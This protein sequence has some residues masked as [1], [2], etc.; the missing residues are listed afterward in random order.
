MIRRSPEQRRDDVQRILDAARSVVERRA[1]LVSALVESTGLHR[2]GVE[3]ALLHCL[4]TSATERELDRLV[5]TAGDAPHVHVI[6]SANVFV[7]AL[8][9]IALARA[10]ARR[11]TVRP[12]SRDPVF[13]EHLVRAIA[14]PAIEIVPDALPRMDE[15]EI[16][17][18]GRDETIARVRASAPPGVVVRGHGAGMGVACISSGD[19]ARAADNLADDVVPFDQRGCLSPRVAFVVGELIRARDFAEKM[20]ASLAARQRTIPRGEL[21][22]VE[23]AEARRYADTLS[24]SGVLHEGEGHKVGVASHLVVPPSGRHVHVVPVATMDA[25]VASLA[26]LERSIVAIGASDTTQLPSGLPP[27][28]RVSGLGVMQ[29]PPLDGPVDQRSS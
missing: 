11:V 6:L 28:A 14:D 16:H 5:A 3:H 27:R 10:A 26:L 12:S 20:H 4:E 15:G 23:R 25:L 29:R 1:G 18:Y 17:V 2:E 21:S 13:A 7:A 9:A 19:I 22:D 24:F 8:R